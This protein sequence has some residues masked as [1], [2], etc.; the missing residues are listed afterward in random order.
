MFYKPRNF[1]YSY[2]QNNKN[3]NIKKKYSS[4]LTDNT[5]IVGKKYF[6]NFNNEISFNLK[7]PHHYN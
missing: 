5:F 3:I 7:D 2:N 1:N 4:D 6:S